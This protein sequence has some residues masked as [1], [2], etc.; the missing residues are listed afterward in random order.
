MLRKRY[1]GI[2]FELSVS[3]KNDKELP[4]AQLRKLE[5]DI[6][7]VVSY[8]ADCEVVALNAL[9]ERAGGKANP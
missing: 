3:F 8:L 7:N 4:L 1:S 5:S 9:K 6:A 2:Q